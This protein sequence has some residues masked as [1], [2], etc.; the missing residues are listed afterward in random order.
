MQRM[1]RLT[2]PARRSA[3]LAASAAGALAS[4]GFAGPALA[5]GQ[6]APACGPKPLLPCNR[7]AVTGP[8]AAAAG[9]SFPLKARGYANQKVSAPYQANA[10]V[11]WN[12]ASPCKTKYAQELSAQGSRPANLDSSVKGHFSEAYTVPASS[13]TVPAGSNQATMHWCVYL[14]N[15]QK[16]TT[17]KAAFWTYSV[18]GHGPGGPGGPGAP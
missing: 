16:K 1:S 14:I 8:I 18:L 10:V 7:L 15:S 5:S 4:L 13:V 3:G 11:G 17:F 2:F 12:T 9:V 6:G